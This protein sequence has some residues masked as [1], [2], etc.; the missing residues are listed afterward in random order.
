MR[1]VCRGK[2]IEQ[3][4]T[5]NGLT[6]KATKISEQNVELFELLERREDAKM[7]LDRYLQGKNHECTWSADMLKLSANTTNW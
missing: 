5:D 1:A 6:L 3:F 7:M 2:Q 4:L